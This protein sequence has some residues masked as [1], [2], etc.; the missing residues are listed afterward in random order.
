VEELGVSLGDERPLEP[1]PPPAFEGPW[2]RRTAEY[3]A[4]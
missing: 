3:R 1:A 4:A 2:W